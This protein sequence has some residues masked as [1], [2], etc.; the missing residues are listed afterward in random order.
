MTIKAQLQTIK[1][2]WLIVI[3]LV[4]LILIVSN[5]NPVT[6]FLEGRGALENY[7]SGDSKVANTG[8]VPPSDNGGISPE[9]ENRI[10]TYSAYISTEIKRGT[11]DK[12]DSKVKDLIDLEDS[13][14]INQN[15]NTYGQNSNKMKQGTYYIRV[16]TS[17]YDSLIDSLKSLGKVNSFNEGADDITSTFT[18]LEIEVQAEEA[19]LERYKQLLADS[20]STDE[21]I[22]LTDKIFDEERRIAYLKEQLNNQGERV[23]YAS[24][25]LTIYEKPSIFSG[26]TLVTLSQIIRDF[27]SSLSSL[28]RLM[29]LIIPYAIGLFVI[30]LIYKKT[31]A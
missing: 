16:P 15:I 26:I 9:I 20:Q 18:N 29:V 3:I 4:V 7:Y 10:I 21:K 14:L 30:W 13:I 19:R 25:S 6:N 5:T 24:I 8:I 23:D 27:V 2:N 31:R 28:I 22:M 1:K 12:A 11:F 17:N